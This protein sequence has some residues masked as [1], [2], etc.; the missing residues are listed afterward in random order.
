MLPTKIS[1]QWVYS[2]FTYDNHKRLKESATFFNNKLS[3]KE[4]YR[5]ASDYSFLPE[6]MIVTYPDGESV[7]QKYKYTKIDDHG[8]WTE[9]VTTL[10]R[11]G[12][13]STSKHTRTITYWE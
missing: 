8:N 6:T 11:R 12:K 9:C 10:F 1:S 4:E 5:Y 3:Q 2:V 13:E 7:I